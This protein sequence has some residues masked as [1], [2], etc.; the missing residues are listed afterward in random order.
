MHQTSTLRALQSASVDQNSYRA[1]RSVLDEI[2]AE[3][4]G[5][6]FLFVSPQSD[7][8]QVSRALAEVASVP[9]LC[10]TS[11]G[12]IWRGQGHIKKGIVGA[13]LAGVRAQVWSIDNLDS[14]CETD[15]TELVA[16]MREFRESEQAGETVSAVV[17]LDGLSQSEE[18]VV[19]HLSHAL[20]GL[21][22][23]G[24]SA[25]DDLNFETT[26]VLANGAFAENQG[27]VALIAS[28]GPTTTFMA[29]HFEP[30][31]TR[32][33]VTA[34]DPKRRRLLE[35]DG[36]PAA[37]AYRLATG[38]GNEP[39]SKEAMAVA[40]LVLSVGGR[41][42]VR[43]LVGEVDEVDGALDLY[44]AIEEGLVLQIGRPT[45]LEGTLLQLFEDI[46]RK[47]GPPQLVLGFDCIL[48]RLEM[49][50][51]PCSD[52][53]RGSLKQNNFFGFSTYGE[54]FG[55]LHVNQTLTGI[56]FGG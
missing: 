21:P 1:T 46:H 35:L 56:A 23:V 13:S 30:T 7:L 27:A 11:A 3:S 19:S 40:P 20:S 22:I 28:P 45:D 17:L 12:E 14:F 24:G 6:N 55:G 16:R 47:V 54:V 9:T 50:L 2:E 5:I 29:H 44:C 31:G 18:R 10:C 52:R 53:V 49:E 41:T 15:A 43:S 39:L 34:A 8:N 25:G 51:F 4:A 48:R 26:K 37:E 32:L 36:M 33:V 42:Y 38:F